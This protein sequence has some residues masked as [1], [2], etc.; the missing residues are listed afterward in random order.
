VGPVTSYQDFYKRY[1]S[2]VETDLKPV[3]TSRT[4]LQNKIIYYQ[5]IDKI[6]RKEKQ[7]IIKKYKLTPPIV[8][9][10]DL[11][12][13]AAYLYDVRKSYLTKMTYEFWFI[14]EQVV[15][16]CQIKKEWLQWITEEEL[17]LILK[18]QLRL[19]VRII[20][21]RKRDS[22]IVGRDGR[23]YYAEGKE[24]KRYIRQMVSQK[25][26]LNVKEFKGLS[27]SNG[28]ASGQVCNI[29]GPAHLNK[30]QK[31]AILVAPQTTV[32]YMAAIRQ[33]AAIIT[34]QGGITSHAAV[35]ARELKIPCIVG[36]KIA[37]KVLKDGDLVEVDADHGLIKIIK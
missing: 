30:M 29:I 27:A 35:I 25:S 6:V 15:R 3:S 1:Q 11:V 14:L 4:E 19:S 16:V 36:T 24:K 9:L 20:N 21:E 18:G 2:I 8:K 17:Y 10:A 12:K 7:E 22:L 26:N 13:D 5:N 23:S 33:A 37:T 34:D 31:G 32:D 28:K